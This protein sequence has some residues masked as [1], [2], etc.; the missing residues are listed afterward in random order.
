MQ[1]FTFTVPYCTLTLCFSRTSSNVFC[2]EGISSLLFSPCRV[3]SGQRSEAS[4]CV[5]LLAAPG[6]AAVSARRLS[7]SLQFH[8]PA[9]PL[10]YPSS[11][12]SCSPL[13]LSPH[14][15]CPPFSL[16]VLRRKPS[17]YHT[18]AEQ[19]SYLYIH[20]SAYL[21]IL[22]GIFGVL[23]IVHQRNDNNNI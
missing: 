18:M 5:A 2:L 17:Q 20:F 1:S 21:F 14:S 9:L 4:S 15:L 13:H 6:R 22:L 11:P 7:V 16:Q 8:W 23:L 10:F 12:L 3:C 19:P